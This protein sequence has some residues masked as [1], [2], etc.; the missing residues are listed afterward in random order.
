MEEKNNNSFYLR[1]KL[2]KKVT[3]EVPIEK[4]K[5]MGWF[6]R[7]IET[8]F[9]KKCFAFCEIPKDLCSDDIQF[10]IDIPEKIYDQLEIGQLISIHIAVKYEYACFHLIKKPEATTIEGFEK[11]EK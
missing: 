2:V 9:E 11:N 1:T 8:V 4:E 3:F 7:K 6:R 5:K 10:K